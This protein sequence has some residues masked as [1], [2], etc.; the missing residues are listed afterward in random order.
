MTE[1]V[2]KHLGVDWVQLACDQYVKLGRS[3]TIPKQGDDYWCRKHNHLTTVTRV[4][5]RADQYIVTCDERDYSRNYGASKLGAQLACTRHSQKH[6]G[7][8]VTL[9]DGNGKVIQESSRAARQESLLD[10][11]DF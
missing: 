5:D 10:Q 1:F 11:P 2:P 6:P 3:V 4:L 7:H 8:H 9:R